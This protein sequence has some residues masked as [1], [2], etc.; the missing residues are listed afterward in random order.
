MNKSSEIKNL[1]AALSKVQAKVKPVIFDSVNPHFKSRYASLAAYIAAI[2]E[3]MGENGLSLSHSV[4]DRD[5]GLCLVS[6]LMHLSGEWVEY[7]TPMILNKND[8]QG[9]CS[10]ETY[11]RR[12]RTAAIAN[13][14]A[15]ED[16]DGN[17]AVKHSPG[18]ANE[19][20]AAKVKVTPPAALNKTPIKI[21][22]TPDKL[23]PDEFITATVFLKGKRI[24]D[25]GI[26][27]LEDW[28][29]KAEEHAGEK[30]IDLNTSF[31]DL[32]KNYRAVRAQV[33]A[34]QPSMFDKFGNLGDMDGGVP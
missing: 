15:D 18:R 16:D 27:Q 23:S 13:V 26:A 14:A 34:L 21:G 30:G 1:A 17:E 10:A 8:M 4:E 19:G 25:L 31:Q 32:G 11:A 28:A 6:L 3:A 24:E 7:L 9:L 33:K 2:Q 12:Y 5:K 22:V 29:T 20:A